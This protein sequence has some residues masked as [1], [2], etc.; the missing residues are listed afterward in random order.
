MIT[1]TFYFGDEILTKMKSNGGSCDRKL[2]GSSVPGMQT[3]FAAGVRALRVK[4]K[5]AQ[6]RWFTSTP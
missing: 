5:K 2:V 3:F 1:A 6:N 4:R